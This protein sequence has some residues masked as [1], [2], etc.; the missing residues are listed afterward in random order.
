MEKHIR[1]KHG[2]NESN[3]SLE[4]TNDPMQLSALAQTQNEGLVETESG[5]ICIN[6][7][8]KEG[9]IDV[10]I[11]KAN[12][13]L[14]EEK[15]DTDDKTGNFIQPN[16]KQAIINNMQAKFNDSTSINESGL[17]E[18]SSI[19]QPQ[20][21]DLHTNSSGPNPELVPDPGT[22]QAVSNSIVSS[23]IIPSEIQAESYRDDIGMVTKVQKDQAK[24]LLLSQT[25]DSREQD[26]EQNTG[27]WGI[28]NELRAMLKKLERNQ[29][30]GYNVQDSNSRN[31]NS[32][33]KDGG[34]PSISS[35]GF[36][37]KL[38]RA[39]QNSSQAENDNINEEKAPEADNQ[40]ANEP[41]S[42]GS[43]WNISTPIP[44]NPF[45]MPF[46]QGF[47]GFGNNLN[48]DPSL[49]ASNNANVSGSADFGNFYN[50]SY[51]TN[52]FGNL[53]SVSGTYF[54]PTPDS[55]QNL[56]GLQNTT[57]SAQIQNNFVNMNNQFGQQMIPLT[58]NELA[59]ANADNMQNTQNQFNISQIK[60][61]FGNTN[62]APN[63]EISNILTRDLQNGNNIRL[64]DQ[65]S[66]VNEMQGKFTPKPTIPGMQ[67]DTTGGLQENRNIP[68]PSQEFETDEN[69]MMACPSCAYK[70]M[71]RLHLTTHIS[72]VHDK[73]KKHACIHCDYESFE[74]A[75]MKRHLELVHNNGQ[76]QQEQPRTYPCPQCDFKGLNQLH[77]SGHIETSHAK[78][79]TFSC[80]ECYYQATQSA[81]LE[82]HVRAVHQKM[83]DYPCPNCDRKFSQMGSLKRHI[84]T[85]HEKLKPFNCSY[86]NPERNY[87]C[88]YKTD[89]QANFDGHIK[90]HGLNGVTNQRKQWTPS[91]DNLGGGAGIG[92]QPS[93]PGF[94]AG[95][96]QGESVVNILKQS[97]E[98]IGSGKNSLFNVQNRMANASAPTNTNL[99]QQNQ[100]NIAITDN[101]ANIQ[102]QVQRLPY[103]IPGNDNNLLQ[104][105]NAF[106]MN[107]FY[108]IQSRSNVPEAQR[109]SLINMQQKANEQQ[110]QRLPTNSR[111][112]LQNFDEKYSKMDI[113]SSKMLGNLLR[114][115]S[116]RNVQPVIPGQPNNDMSRM[117]QAN[118]YS[119]QPNF[120]AFN[121]GA[122][123]PNYN[124]PYMNSA[125]QAGAIQNMK[126]SRDTEQQGFQTRRSR[127]QSDGGGLRNPE[128]EPAPKS[129][130]KRRNR[131]QST[132]NS[133]HM[134]QMGNF[135]P[136]S[137]NPQERGMGQVPNQ[138]Q[139]RNNSGR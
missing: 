72:R 76:L 112:S 123:N 13:Q 54:P 37:S 130:T 121:Q 46:G 42:L 26:N 120:N 62:I 31:D 92:G 30:D 106:N 16:E 138:Y 85:V 109:N 86:S 66:K 101:M 59:K 129:F 64:E 71:K 131:Q 111:S 83:S 38:K 84:T 24:E 91:A 135:Q 94:Q 50:N 23:N 18:N 33:K 5:Q 88:D 56:T 69:G 45:Q 89:N 119:N 79:Q 75:S 70:T 100:A 11:S 126:K 137:F 58:P 103:Q 115:Q 53:K 2:R 87:I 114:V 68:T 78:Q 80:T 25:T 21:L 10:Q 12:E 125:M 20:I 105:P 36:L 34:G 44:N 95:L 134:N 128:A 90:K 9:S 55:L 108:N 47:S 3:Q 17:A 28:K 74:K 117:Q 77:L 122:L 104:Q 1:K 15:P 14:N 139:H 6:D 107:P 65:F 29:L 27:D 102:Q 61:T 52:N 7:K 99:F 51:M 73:I 60:D 116:S 133:L 118:L 49:P 8:L 40:P 136:N 132:G 41:L 113:E 35:G 127:L 97:I 39:M 81:H 32:E 4:N 43:S 93:I 19:L 98:D 96:N 82:S 67:N 124:N 57:L 22:V 110:Q 48:Q 63:T